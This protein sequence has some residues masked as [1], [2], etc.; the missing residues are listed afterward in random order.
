MF[1]FF[2]C[3]R[4]WRWR[5]AGE[6]RAADGWGGRAA[7]TVCPLAARP[8]G[9]GTAADTRHRLLSAGGRRHGD[10]WDAHGLVSRGRG[11]ALF[12]RFCVLA[13]TASLDP[14][15]EKRLLLPGSSAP[16]SALGDAGCRR[17]AGT[18]EGARCGAALRPAEPRRRP[19]AGTQ[20]SVRPL[21][22]YGRTHVGEKAE[23]RSGGG[24]AAG[25][26]PQTRL[27]RE[28]PSL[29]TRS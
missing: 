29:V 2:G 11:G 12:V 25:A 27:Q 3:L 5:R 18:R 8:R 7:G 13:P 21:R 17:G 1:F 16:R 20:R 19:P 22:S 26:R 14:A 15:A 23:A 28:I 10:G 6:P 9:T 4:R 24:S